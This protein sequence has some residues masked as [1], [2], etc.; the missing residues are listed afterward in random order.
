[1]PRGC[2]VQIPC[3]Q[4]SGKATYVVCTFHTE[5][6]QLVRRRRCRF[7]DHRWYTVQN[8]EQLLSKCNIKWTGRSRIVQIQ[9][10]VQ[11]LDPAAAEPPASSGG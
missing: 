3:P 11:C 1:M 8:P 2:V 10:E 4:C 7:C 9:D 5:A 6:E